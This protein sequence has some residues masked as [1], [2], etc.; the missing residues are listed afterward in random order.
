MNIL[1]QFKLRAC[2]HSCG[3]LIIQRHKNLVCIMMLYT[4]IYVYGEI[5]GYFK[6][7]FYIWYEFF[8]LISSKNHNSFTFLQK[9]TWN[10][11]TLEKRCDFIC[12][13]K[14]K[15]K[16]FI[17]IWLNRS[18]WFEILDWYHLKWKLANFNVGIKSLMVLFETQFKKLQLGFKTWIITP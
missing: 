6:F 8:P 1:L 16:N 13:K 15:I 4:V 7:N 18:V 5:F 3:F 11:H 12:E 2:S 17:E 10:F 14:L 9:K